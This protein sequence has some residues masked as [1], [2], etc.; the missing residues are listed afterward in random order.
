M[1]FLSEVEKRLDLPPAEKAQVMRELRSHYEELRSAMIASGVEAA[2]AD[3]E[4]ARKLGDPADVAFRLQ[5]VH[6]RAT[7]K[8]ALLTALPL[9]AMLI[10][11]LAKFP[12]MQIIWGA[13]AQR[14]AVYEYQT[15]VL[16]ATAV[17][18]VIFL[19][20]SIRELMRNRR[21]MWLATW[22]AVGVREL[23]RAGHRLQELTNWIEGQRMPQ[24]GI[25]PS[26]VFQI[27]VVGLLAMA[28]FRR[29]AKWFLILGGWTLLTEV[30]Y[31]AAPW[32]SLNT[33]WFLAFLLLVPAPLVM[34]VALGLFARHPYGNTA[35]ASLFLFAL[36]VSVSSFSMRDSH[37]VLPLANVLPPIV[38]VMTVLAYARS[39]T[40]RRKL[41]ILAAGIVVAG[42]ADLVIVIS[43]YL[44]VHTAF[45]LFWVIL[46]PMLFERRWSGR[47]PE[48]AR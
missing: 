1:E 46:V 36:Y 37:W 38:I 28:M 44:A 6:C 2:Q 12:L 15:Y 21:P 42:M 48:L 31:I 13:H 11:S 10:V 25:F 33:G 26:V 23:V 19:T 43:G 24:V 3:Q 16:I 39:S 22:L 9:A 27:L 20:G 14:S 4:A 18:G 35:S 47:R 45:M 41:A 30:I 40:W 7:W 8:T 29:S 34:A 5:S 17:L 32:A